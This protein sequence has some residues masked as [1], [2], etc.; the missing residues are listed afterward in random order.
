MKLRDYQVE[1]VEALWQ[2]LWRSPTALMVLPTGTGKTE[3][4]QGLV[5]KALSAKPDFKAC[6]LVNRK[7]LLR[8]TANRFSRNLGAHLV[9]AFRLMD[10]GSS[11]HQAPVL[12]A[13]IQSIAKHAGMFH[14]LI[15]D[16]AQNLN[17]DSGRYQKMIEKCLELNPNLKIVAVTATPYRYSGLIYGTKKLF[18]RVCF[19]RDLQWAWRNKHLVPVKLKHTPHQFDTSK[20]EVRMGDYVQKQVEALTLDERKMIEQIKD[21]MPQLEGRRAVVWACS[22]IQH[23]ESVA[24]KIFAVDTQG[25]SVVH[26][27]REDRDEQLSM[28]TSGKSRHLVF[29]SIVSEGFDHPPTDAVVLMRPTRSPVLY[30][31]IIGRGLRPSPHKADCIVLDYGGVVENLGPLHSPNIKQGKDKKSQL[32][33]KMKFC[34]NCLEY[35]ESSARICPACTAPFSMER[36]DDKLK[37]LNEK[38]YNGT[39][40]ERTLRVISIS[41]SDRY[42]SKSGN[43]CYV[44]TYHLNSLFPRMHQEYIVKNGG[45]TKR[46]WGRLTSLGITSLKGHDKIPVEAEISLKKNGA[47]YE[48]I[49]VKRA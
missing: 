2:E 34:Q 7:E 31:Q 33:I 47:Y 10:I 3:V 42:V 18:K 41:V 27:K 17:E 8:Q 48:I 44:I 43:Q 28:F 32:I 49:G 19:E 5:Q 9:Q 45:G 35:V 22:S 12:V 4:L 14:L 30:V 38:S 24:S 39:G 21:A 46:L 11:K 13:T 25:V 26:S 6:F 20:L 37:N 15:V 23:A 1:A 36:L 16:E 40:T 29:V